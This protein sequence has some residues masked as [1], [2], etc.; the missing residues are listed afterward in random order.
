MIS[1]G[2]GSTFC[3]FMMAFI[4]A[5]PAPAICIFDSF[6]LSAPRGSIQPNIFS[7]RFFFTG[8]ASGRRSTFNPQKVKNIVTCWPMA[9][10]P[11]AMINEARARSNSPENTI[12]VFAFD[13][14]PLLTA[15]SGVG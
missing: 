9:A 15:A 7:M 10:A 6:N 14:F 3:A 4:M 11:L 5:V 12:K 8:T 13:P 1:W 2:N